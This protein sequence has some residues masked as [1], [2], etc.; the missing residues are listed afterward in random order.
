[1]DGYDS[2]LSHL[3]PT[4]L[5]QAREN[6]AAT[7]VGNYALFGG[8]RMRLMM[9]QSYFDVVDAYNTSLTR[10]TPTALSRARA[11]LAAT[12]VGNYALFGGGGDEDPISRVDAYDETLT[13]TTP[14]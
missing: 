1:V 6:L 5:S 8:G 11:E 10:S 4:A 14:A 9:Q 13:K 2:T 3:T 12:T 7:T